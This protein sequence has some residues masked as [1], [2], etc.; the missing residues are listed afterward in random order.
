MKTNIEIEIAIFDGLV[1]VYIKKAAHFR[2]SF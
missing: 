1:Q 2:S